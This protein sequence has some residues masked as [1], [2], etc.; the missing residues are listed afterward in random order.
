MLISARQRLL[1]LLSLPL[2]AWW[3][4]QH[5]GVTT[6]SSVNPMYADTAQTFVQAPQVSASVASN[7]SSSSPGIFAASLRGTQHDGSLRVDSDGL[8]IIERGIR[9][10][11]EYYLTT[12]GEQSEAAIRK[13]LLALIH[14]QLPADAAQ[15]AEQILAAY[16]QYRQQSGALQ[17]AYPALDAN[18]AVSVVTDYFAARQALRE[19]LFSQEV[20]D[21]FFADDMRNEQQAGQ[22]LQQVLDARRLGIAPPVSKKYA[23]NPAYERYYQAL[24]KQPQQTAEQLDAIRA[25][26][27]GTAVA[28]RLATLDEKRRN[29]NMRFKTYRGE[30]QQLLAYADAAATDPEPALQALQRDMFNETEIRRVQALDRFADKGLVLVH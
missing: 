24:A 22:Q 16:L 23:A 25:N 18:N 2:F 27:F 5:Q 4:L 19:E 30:R 7:R 21:A 28:E 26:L 9:D 14:R 17:Q 15:Q 29:W 1:L 11:F 10:L 12:R 8:L 20:L 6:F 3:L 13:Q